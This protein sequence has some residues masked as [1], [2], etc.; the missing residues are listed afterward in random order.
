[1]TTSLVAV[2]LIVPMAETHNDS[3]DISE[4]LEEKRSWLEL[5]HSPDFRDDVSKDVASVTC[6]EKKYL[7]DS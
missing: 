3:L 7:P 6:H 5:T 4:C 1:M 2:E